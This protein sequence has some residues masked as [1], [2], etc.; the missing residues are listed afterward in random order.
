MARTESRTKT[1]IWANPDF[2]KLPGRAQRMYWLLYSQPTIS[3]CGVVA[4]T[5]R[6]WASSASDE[7]TDTVRGAL[8]ELQDAD[9]VLIDYDT[10]EVLV[11]TFARHDGVWRSPKTFGPAWHQL[12]SIGSARLRVEAYKQLTELGSPPAGWDPI[13]ESQNRVSDTLCHTPS[14]T[15]PD[16]VFQLGINRVC[17]TPSDR[18]RTRAQAASVL[19]PQPPSPSPSSVPA[20]TGQGDEG[21]LELRKGL[22][23]DGPGRPRRDL[24]L[25]ERLTR[26]CHTEQ[27]TRTIR[28]EAAAVAAWA[29]TAVD[30]NLLEEAIGWAEAKT[31]G[32]Q[33]IRLPRAIASVVRQKALDRGISM[34][35]FPALRS[36]G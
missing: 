11:R 16:R 30:S 23:T 12:H 35:A 33:P 5:E 1:A 8:Q 6:R 28:T 34:P 9:F 13:P 36:H 26:A 22:K 3:L 4:L 29:L 21:D 19:R 25:V 14:D 20:P 7:T 10:E 15:P 32:D 2:T 17:D 18:P 27:D 31:G 24:E